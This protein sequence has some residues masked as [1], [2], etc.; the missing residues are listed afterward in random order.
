MR[1]RQRRKPVECR[2]VKTRV[3]RCNDHRDR[4][5]V[6][7]T[8][9][10]HLAENSVKYRPIGMVQDVFEWLG[11]RFDEVRVEETVTET[12]RMEERNRQR[13]SVDFVATV[14]FGVVR[15]RELS[16]EQFTYD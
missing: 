11:H 3:H 12:W 6:P 16:L 1:F 2:P 7:L 9:G 5:A 15:D 4:E 10:P 14:R 8:Q 13:N